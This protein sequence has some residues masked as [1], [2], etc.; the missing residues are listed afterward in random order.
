MEAIHYIIYIKVY[1]LK[2]LDVV[3]CEQ[4]GF[5]KVRFR[6]ECFTDQTLPEGA[7]QIQRQRHVRP[8]SN[9]QQLAK[10]VQQLL[11]SASDGA[12]RQNV[13]PLQHK[14]VNPL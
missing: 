4:V 3:E 10:E 9:A 14:R 6:V 1:I 7:E 13:L 2:L 5:S 11:F 12:R 8:D